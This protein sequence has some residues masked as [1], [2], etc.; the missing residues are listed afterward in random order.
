[1][2][3]TILTKSFVIVKRVELLAENGL[4][5]NNMSKIQTYAEEMREQ[6]FSEEQISD[7]VKTLYEVE[8]QAKISN[9]IITNIF[10]KSVAE[11]LHEL[12]N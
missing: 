12:N 10:G 5:K 6:G 8:Q 9:N 11:Q 2:E 7:A 3:V 1:M 4:A